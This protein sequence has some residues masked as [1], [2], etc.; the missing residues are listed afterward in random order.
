MNTAAPVD[1]PPTPAPDPAA[2]ASPASPASPAPVA[3]GRHLDRH[4][5]HS[6]AWS[7]ASRWLMQLV[8]WGST[9]VV[10]RLLSPSDYG[11]IGY[12]TL[13]MGFV[14]MVSE[15]GFGSAIVV[16]RGLSQEEIEQINTVSMLSGLCAF[17]ISC[18]AAVPLGHYFRAP[19]LPPVVLVLATT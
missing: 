4:M 1:L 10:T 11:L 17:V 16:L 9:I 5:F 12:A 14:T 2:P 3:A 6:L 8:T 18:A 19:N 15:L 13:Y 7:A